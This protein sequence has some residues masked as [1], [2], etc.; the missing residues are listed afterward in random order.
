M[1]YSD[2]S[3]PLEA[4]CSVEKKRNRSWKLSVMIERAMMDAMEHRGEMLILTME[5]FLER[6]IL[7]L[8][9]EHRW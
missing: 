2:V 8:R 4:Y 5:S 3:Y 9:W 1:S 6:V 7:K